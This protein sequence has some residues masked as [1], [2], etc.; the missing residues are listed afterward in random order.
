MASAV[1]G[2]AYGLILSRYEGDIVFLL[3]ALNCSFIELLDQ[4]LEA[5]VDQFL[6][7]FP[8]DPVH[9]KHVQLIQG[10]I[11]ALGGH[12][13]APIQ[14]PKR[15]HAIGICEAAP[16]ASH[17]VND[18]AQK[19]PAVAPA[20]VCPFAGEQGS[21]WPHELWLVLKQ[22]ASGL[23]HQIIRLALEPLGEIRCHSGG[24][25]DAE[26]LLVGEWA[27]GLIGSPKDLTRMLRQGGVV[28]QPLNL[29]PANQG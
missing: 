4:V 9:G 7:C 28:A 23:V 10:D 29:S 22:V 15:C 26:Q 13:H 17:G 3:S 16:A 27:T 2:N 5:G 21:T 6:I 20:G 25:A 11:Q 1:S 19:I 24:C 14:L 12:I 8:F 18:D